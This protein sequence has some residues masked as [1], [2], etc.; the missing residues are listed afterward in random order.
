MRNDSFQRQGSIDT[1]QLM[2]YLIEAREQYCNYLRGV[3]TGQRKPDSAEQEAL[4]AKCDET[5]CAWRGGHEAKS[6]AKY[7]EWFFTT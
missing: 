5:L 2:T 4:K 3:A 7:S 1:R 6:F